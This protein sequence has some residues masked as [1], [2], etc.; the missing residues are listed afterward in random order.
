MTPGQYRPG[1]ERRV[2]VAVT[3]SGAA[4]RSLRALHLAGSFLT[5]LPRLAMMRRPLKD[6]VA[7]LL[8]TRTR[9]NVSRHL[10]RMWAMPL[11]SLRAHLIDHSLRTLMPL[12]RNVPRRITQLRTLLLALLP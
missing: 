10:A 7:H 11:T 9:G 12:R 6:A 1:W 4:L 8:P 5:A 2:D 3:F